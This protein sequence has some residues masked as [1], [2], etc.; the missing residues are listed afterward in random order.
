MSTATSTWEHPD[1]LRFNALPGGRALR[2]V[3]H[4]KRWPHVPFAQPPAGSALRPV[5]GSGGLPVIGR[6]VEAL[7]DGPRFTQRCYDT[8]GPV[9]WNR[10]FG[11]RMVTAL[12]PDATQAVLANADKAFS[13][14]GWEYF[15]G[16][17][18]RR[19]LML[20]DAGE[21]MLH[22]RI[23]QEAFVRDRLATYLNRVDELA[24]KDIAGWPMHAQVF[25]YPSIKKL[26][27]DIASDIFMGGELDAAADRLHTAFV[28]TVR[29][30]TAV[31]RKP[32]GNGKWARGLKGRAVLEEFFR[33]RLPA[34]RATDGDDLFAAL[35]H[36]RTD[37]GETFSDDDVVSHMI[38]LMMAA[39]DTSTI[40]SS[41]VV[42][43]L[44]AHPEWQEKARAES[45]A[46]DGPLSLDVLDS[47]TTLDL[48]IKETLRIV[49]PVP[50]LARKTVADTELVGHFVPAGT[51][52]G[53]S[54]WFNHYMPEIW[55]NPLAFDP[56]R[57]AEG[58][59]EDKQHRF[60]YVPF[61]G[62]AHKCIG[63]T[64]GV[65][66]VKT[67]VHHLLRTRRFTVPPGYRTT[68]DLTSLPVPA[69]GM[70]VQLEPLHQGSLR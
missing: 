21:H 39:H 16:P 34:K 10:A 52:V 13:Q 43:Q 64:F 49:A 17:F 9:S 25:M 60:A 54:P 67:L 40:T 18:F 61:G 15:I 2:A 20:L 58:R 65:N 7:L 51:L 26:S 27:L 29:A 8:Y 36:A 45:L 66:E 53:I 14:T 4:R 24:Q 19:G 5:D 41:A 6:S 22:R 50:S 31:V 63:M 46:V 12:G 57:F 42:G 44:A 1:R 48:C 47:L 23:M 30:G 28:D 59:R 35:C 56:E 70:P 37:D 68:W 3:L 69:D 55:S 11:I 62:G 32:I 38:F 33:S